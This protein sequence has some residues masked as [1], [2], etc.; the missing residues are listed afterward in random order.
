[1]AKPPCGTHWC[2]RDR[3]AAPGLSRATSRPQALTR[4][5]QR[6]LHG[7]GDLLL[8]RHAAEVGQPGP[9]KL[10]LSYRHLQQ[11]IVRICADRTHPQQPARCC[12]ARA[13]A[14]LVPWHAW[15]GDWRRARPR[16]TQDRSGSTSVWEFQWKQ[17][18][19]PSTLQL[20]CLPPIFRGRH[21]LWPPAPAAL[22][23]AMNRDA[24]RSAGQPEHPA[25]PHLLYSL[26]GSLP[27]PP[28]A[29]IPASAAEA[30]AALLASS[31]CRCLCSS[32][33]TRRACGHRDR[34]AAERG[35]AQMDRAGS[36][37]P[38]STSPSLT[39]ASSGSA[40]GS[41]PNSKSLAPRPSMAPPSPA[42]MG[43][44]MRASARLGP[45]GTVTRWEPV[46]SLPFKVLMKAVSLS[47]LA[48]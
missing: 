19:L 24:S 34:Q 31:S 3:G 5:L 36:P 48:S 35:R 42:R 27:S 17:R 25:R 28:V 2:P 40:L 29:A 32:M 44:L 10:L 11:S 6:H 39:R 18:Q 45:G 38:P 43:E 26:P 33:E 21:H 1:M 4:A 14:T 22:G 41:T 23:T 47:V 46:P 30:A 9:A 20:N 13:G 7:I 37:E 15:D 8:L 12:P 16:S